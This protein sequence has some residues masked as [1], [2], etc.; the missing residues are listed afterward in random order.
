MN[1]ELN[2]THL[3]TSASYTQNGMVLVGEV[4]R[5]YQSLLDNNGY[6]ASQLG[7]WNFTSTSAQNRICTCFDLNRTRSNSSTLSANYTLLNNIDFSRCSS[8]GTHPWSTGLGW[9]PIGNCSTTCESGTNTPY[10]G[11]FSGST[12][13][14]KNLYINRPTEDGTALFGITTNQTAVSGK[15]GFITNLGVFG[16]V[17]GDD[18]VGGIVG[19]G[20]STT[21]N[22]SYSSGVIQGDY[23][24]GGII[25]SGR[26]ANI[27]S[28]WFRGR[29]P[30]G[31]NIGGIMG[32]GT[33]STINNSFAI[34]DIN[35]GGSSMGGVLGYASNANV[36]N[37]YAIS[38]LNGSSGTGGLI[39]YMWSN[40]NV[41]N[42]YAISTIYGVD[43]AGGLIG[44]FYYSNVNSSFARATI[45]T[46]SS[47]SRR[48]GGLIGNGY[49]SNIGN[50][51]ATSTITIASGSKQVGGLV[52]Y[53]VRNVT[54][55]Y[56]TVNVVGNGSEVGGLVGRLNYPD[57]SI[58]VN[59]Y[60]LGSIDGNYS[61][62]G[63]VGNVSTDNV[64][65]MNSYSTLQVR[66]YRSTQPFYVGGIAGFVSGSNLT[67]TNVTWT[68][69]TDDNATH[70]RG[71]L[72]TM[73]GSA[74]TGCTP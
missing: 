52:G 36:H 56:A 3:D 42:S 48:I 19:F 49:Q 17:T 7:C 72:A 37:S 31:D 53:D 44:Q 20:N 27:T 30:T 6:S 69:Y 16:S 68:N 66:S 22:N 24:V 21:V 23:G 28:V 46:Q 13:F 41:T 12:F 74:I 55:S 70:C 54:N 45:I 47:T 10:T 60:A 40:S 62:G 34:V 65:F 26:L 63:L 39:G 71:A 73:A 4:A 29:M 43:E 14:I 2:Y 11:V 5:K 35:G 9:N 61:L 1:L 64:L 38:T 50:S 8:L 57:G 67:T 15:H 18:F 51:Y 32:F 58:F 59:S 33:R 25:G